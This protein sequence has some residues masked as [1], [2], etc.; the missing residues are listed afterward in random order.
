MRS[1]KYPLFAMVTFLA[2]TCLGPGAGAQEENFPNSVTVSGGMV[3]GLADGTG[4][5][6]PGVFTWNG[7]GGVNQSTVPVSGF[8]WRSGM[9]LVC[10][11]R[12]AT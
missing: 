2:F 3:V 8:G 9:S 5:T 10:E 7:S 1:P 6:I 4:R 11:E 12:D